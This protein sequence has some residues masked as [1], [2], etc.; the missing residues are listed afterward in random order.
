MPQPPLRSYLST[1]LLL[2]GLA[3]CLRAAPPPAGM[4]TGTA[5]TLEAQPA[6]G[7]AVTLTAVEP[8][9]LPS[10]TT[11]TDQNG[12]FD[13]EGVRVG[14]YGLTVIDAGS[15]TGAYLPELVIAP[16]ATT[17]VALRLEALGSISG[18]ARLADHGAGAIGLSLA[19][20]GTS[21]ALQADGT[22]LLLG[23]PPGR[24][25]VIASAPGYAPAFSAIA[26]APGEAVTLTDELV[27]QRV[28][29][30]AR[31]TVSVDGATVHVDGSGS[32]DADGATVACRWRFGDEATDMGCVTSYAFTSSGSQTIELTV[33]DAAGNRSSASAQVEI[34]LPVV[35][36]DGRPVTI[37]LGAGQ[38][39]WFD[40]RLP[41]GADLLYLEAAPGL[42]LGAKQGGRAY[43]SNSAGRFGLGSAAA[44]PGSLLPQA[45]DVNAICGGP[46]ILLAPAGGPVSVGV[47]NS[48]GQPL[49][50]QFVAYPDSFSDEAEPNDRASAATTL[51]G[52][53]SGAIELV[54]DRDYYRAA[55]AGRVTFEYPATSIALRATLYSASGVRRGTLGNGAPAVVAAGD[56]VVVEAV[57]DFAAPAGRSLYFLTLE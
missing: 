24:H 3:G 19:G 11:T 26:L 56:L 10:R 46:C 12:R 48:S 30:Y 51:A 7:A 25:R 40:V 32:T 2:L 5:S 1:L 45:V 6:A 22:F 8:A 44:A 37:T 31:F 15:G 21:A 39:A 35:V 23:V 29:P 14:E 13:I 49:R 53:T 42:L 54:G 28:A 20:T 41:A 55:S 52:S 17:T 16:D 38:S 33:V 50:A 43:V 36:P 47:T 34:L 18:V 9:N 27:L 57:G 4:L